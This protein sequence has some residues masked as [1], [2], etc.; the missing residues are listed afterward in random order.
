METPQ[1]SSPLSLARV[2]EARDVFVGVRSAHCP[3]AV[4]DEDVLQQQSKLEHRIREL[5]VA[6]IGIAG[7]IRRVARRRRIVGKMNRGHRAFRDG[8]A[9]AAGASRQDAMSGKCLL[10]GL[11]G[12]CGKGS[13]PRV[14]GGLLGDQ[15]LHHR[16]RREH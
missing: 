16:M 3:E 8:I 12:L 2:P 10:D 14:D 13:D 1:S 15:V 6:H 11:P 4:H 9:A 7:L 5:H